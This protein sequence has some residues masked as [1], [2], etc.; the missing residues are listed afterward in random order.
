MS[1]SSIKQREKEEHFTNK[2]KQNNFYKAN[3]CHNNNFTK[4]VKNL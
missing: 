1:M 4:K 3:S 2:L